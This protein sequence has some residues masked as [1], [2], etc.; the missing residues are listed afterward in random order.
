MWDG[1]AFGKEIASAMADAIERATAPLVA[2][3]VELEARE[4]PE[5]QVL[6]FPTPEPIA[7]EVIAEQVRSY[8]EANPPAPGKDGVDGVNG[9]DGR[10]G[11]DGL[12]GAPGTDGKDGEKGMDG[13]AGPVVVAAIKDHEGELILSLTDGTM[14]KTGIF[15]GRP[16]EK[17]LDGKD[18]RDG[19]GL[20]SFDTELKEDGRTLLLKFV[21]GDTTETH[22]LCFPVVID[23]GVYKAE[24]EYA[25]GDGVTFGGSF[26]IAQRETSAKPEASDD[27]RLAVKRG[28]DGKDGPQGSPGE[29][30]KKGDPGRDGRNYV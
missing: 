8:L 3:I 1:E 27:W 17:G 6:N 21:S 20:D 2:R 4:I 16:G 12:P 9:S 5:V 28:R 18:G 19:F 13:Q 26:W 29:T 30:G 10:D 14:L 23:R 24:T 25:Q 7:P 22:E 11:V 15:D